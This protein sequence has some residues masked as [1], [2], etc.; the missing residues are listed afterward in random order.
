M[1]EPR[2]ESRTATRTLSAMAG[3]PV[4]A[5]APRASRADDGAAARPGLD[6]ADR[7]DG[8]SNT[9]KQLRDVLRI[10]LRDD[11]GHADAAIEGPRELLRLDLALRLQEG[12]QPRL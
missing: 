10:V 5:G 1:F 8:F 7:E 2:P 3:G 4:G 12:H 9:F 6:M 11:Q